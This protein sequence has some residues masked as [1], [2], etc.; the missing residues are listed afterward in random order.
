MVQ[1]TRQ[2]AFQPRKGNAVS[3]PGLGW[4]SVKAEASEW[5]QSGGLAGD[6]TAPL[7]T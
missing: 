7:P 2:L 3:W 4:R 1:M 5:E 6:F